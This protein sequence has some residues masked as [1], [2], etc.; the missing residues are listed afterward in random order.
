MADRDQGS[1]TGHLPRQLADRLRV[2]VADRGRP[3]GAFMLA[4]LPAKKIVLE[5]VISSRITLQKR[6]VVQSFR[7]EDMSKPEH[8]R[9]VRTGNNGKPLGIQ[10]TRKIVCQR[11]DEYEMRTASAR[12][13]QFLP[14]GMRADP[15]TVDIG[16][17]DRHSTEG[18]HQLAAAF[19]RVPGHALAVEAVIRSKHMGDYDHGSA[20]TIR[21]DG[22]DISAKDVQK[23]VN[24]A[25]CVM[26]PA[27]TRPAIGA[28]EH[29]ARAMTVIDPFQLIRDQLRRFGPADLDVIVSAASLRVAGLAFKPAPPDG[30][31][32]DA[33]GAVGNRWKI[34]QK[35]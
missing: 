24:L 27:G 19:D 32:F 35:R 8:H 11:A 2:N 10:I 29:C 14:Y 7:D 1:G 34:A 16:V 26:K 28:A 18:E 17:L 5:P 25:L 13:G 15:S 33:N 4:V 6:P 30:R 20:G 23:A 12:A 21:V 3:F 31:P 9:H 22:P